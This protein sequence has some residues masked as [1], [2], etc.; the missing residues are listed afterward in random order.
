[1]ISSDFNVSKD[2][3][4]VRISPRHDIDSLIDMLLMFLGANA[5][6]N[7]DRYLNRSDE[8]KIT[9]KQ[10]DVKHFNWFFKNNVSIWLF[11]FQDLNDC[12]DFIEDLKEFREKNWDS[13]SDQPDYESLRYILETGLAKH[14]HKLN[15]QKFGWQN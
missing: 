10:L 5:L 3:P 7:P 12:V 15:H 4:N 6:E 9:R 13:L 14:K 1:M 11:F 2:F 8:W